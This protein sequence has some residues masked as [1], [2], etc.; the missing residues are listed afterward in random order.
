MFSFGDRMS[1]T[2]RVANAG[3]TIVIVRAMT[4]NCTENKSIEVVQCPTRAVIDGHVT[5]RIDRGGSVCDGGTHL[6]ITRSSIVVSVV[7]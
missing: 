3:R 2:V 1:S 4:T 5:G 6:C 7:S